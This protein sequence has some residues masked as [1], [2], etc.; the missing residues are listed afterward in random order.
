MEFESLTAEMMCM[1]AAYNNRPI[2]H[3]E[4]V[5]LETTLQLIYNNAVQVDDPRAEGFSRNPLTVEVR[6]DG[7]WLMALCAHD[8]TLERTYSISRGQS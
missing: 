5:S 3:K 2:T 6:S 7:L 1:L 8:L 4:L